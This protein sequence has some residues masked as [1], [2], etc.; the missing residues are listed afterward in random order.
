M[1]RATSS[2]NL[3]NRELWPV[4]YLRGNQ[5]DKAGKGGVPLIKRYGMAFLKVQMGR[6]LMMVA[7]AL[8]SWLICHST[9]VDA[10]LMNGT[11]R[12]SSSNKKKKMCNITG[13][14]GQLVFVP[15]CLAKRIFNAHHHHKTQAR[16]G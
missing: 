1:K 2:D 6:Q 9:A 12:G 16:L 4:V 7:S 3:P 10:I 13:S 15:C 14:I 8:E 11:R 5:G